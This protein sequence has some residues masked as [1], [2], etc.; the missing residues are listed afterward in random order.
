MRIE[1]SSS[2]SL[3]FVDASSNQLGWGLGLSTETLLTGE[4]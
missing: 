3:F 1:T 2:S 4:L